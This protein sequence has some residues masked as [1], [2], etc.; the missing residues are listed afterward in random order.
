MNVKN[1]IYRAVIRMQDGS[2][3]RVDNRMIEDGLGASINY[4]NLPKS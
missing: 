2:R 4:R 1:R 3:I